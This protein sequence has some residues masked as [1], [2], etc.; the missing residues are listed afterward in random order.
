MTLEVVHGSGGAD[1]SRGGAGLRGA[2]ARGNGLKALVVDDEL[3][4]CKAMQRALSIAG[5]DVVVAQSG[6]SAL[7]IIRDERV[8]VMLIDLR[9]P[10]MR[11]DIVF[12]LA[13]ATQPHLAFQTLFMTGDITENA[14]ALI[15]A[16]GCHYLQ[17]P[18]NLSDLTDAMA[19]VAPKVRDRLA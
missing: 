13:A 1:E 8:D 10:D 3:S 11:G 7:A 17:K 12:E 15:A 16:C 9:I 6:E 18:F 5:Y 2:A 14:Q 19:A 4:I